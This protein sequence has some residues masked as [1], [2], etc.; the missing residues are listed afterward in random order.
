MYDIQTGGLQG[1]KA[2]LDYAM[3]RG[4]DNEIFF[5]YSSSEETFKVLYF[6][7]KER[8]FSVVQPSKKI[9]EIVNERTRNSFS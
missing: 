2:T 5:N 4:D 3:L 6:S 1:L 7:E 9:S 8:T